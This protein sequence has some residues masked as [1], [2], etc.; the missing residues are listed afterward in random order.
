MTKVADLF[1]KYDGKEVIVEGTYAS[2]DS[3]QERTEPPQRTHAVVRLEGGGVALEPRWSEDAVRPKGEIK[4][5]DGKKILV[6]GVFHKDKKPPE[7]V[8]TDQ[9]GPY[10]CISPVKAIEELPTVTKVADLFAK[11]DGKEVIVEGTYASVDVRQ[12]R[13]GPAQRTH[14][15]VQLEGG[16][17]ALEPRWSEYAVRPKGEDKFLDGKK[18]RVRGVFH[19]DK[20]PP[21]GVKTDQKGPHVCISP[22]KAMEPLEE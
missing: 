16:G 15:V 22:V 9:E 17:V 10:V 3:R 5:L 6:R 13:T 11:Y 8:K 20:K 21:K 19:K 18:I 12:E 7:G 4:I 1:T 2:V 14:A